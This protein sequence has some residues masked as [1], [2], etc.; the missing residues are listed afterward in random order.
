MN[1]INIYVLE[2][3]SID[4]LEDEPTNESL[5]GD[6]GGY[7]NTTELTTYIRIEDLQHVITEKNTGVNKTFV[8]EY[9]VFSTYHNI[10]QTIF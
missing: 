1:L 6:D 7:Y 10:E 4:E 8:A 5:S 9:K 2:D 3:Q